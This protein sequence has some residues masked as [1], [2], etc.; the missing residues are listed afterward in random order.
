MNVNRPLLAGQNANATVAPRAQWFREVEVPPAPGMG[1][2]RSFQHEKDGLQE[3]ATCP[4]IY[5]AF[6]TWI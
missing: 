5:D 4:R 1:G 6:L 3:L 2:R